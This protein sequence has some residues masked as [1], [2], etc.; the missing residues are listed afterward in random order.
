MVGEI[1]DNETAELAIHAGLTGHFVLST[2]HTNDAIGAIPR[3]LDM[4]VEPFLLASTLN[5]VVAQRLARKICPH[6]R[7]AIEI[8]INIAN[9]I[10]KE[11]KNIPLDL[12]KVIPDFNINKLVYYKGTGCQL[13]ANLG[14]QGR[15]AIAEVL[16]INNN[17][18]EIIISQN[19]ILTLE[20][21]SKNQEFINMSQDGILKVLQGITT[22]EEI[23]R[24][25]YN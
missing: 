15:V 24:I 16:N 7:Q 25:I 2:L 19:K 18:K 20:E 17:I 8:P 3:L 13:C 4:K 21:I 1:R 11:L 23:L 5:A 6:C 12:N 22:W 10:K 14:Y 9:I